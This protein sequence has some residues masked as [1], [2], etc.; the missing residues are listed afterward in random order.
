MRDG[1][2]EALGTTT[3]P[4]P[5]RSA[6]NSLVDYAEGHTI[7]CLPCGRTEDSQCIGHIGH[8]RCLKSEF[9]RRDACPLCR[10]KLPT[11]GTTELTDARK[12]MLH[13]AVRRLRMLTLSWPID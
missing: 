11:Y 5:P 4:F 9:K 7:L 12:N 8:R 6:C 10:H 2:S 3:S 13:L 1:V